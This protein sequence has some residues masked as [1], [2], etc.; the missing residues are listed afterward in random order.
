MGLKSS[1]REI[2]ILNYLGFE[3]QEEFDKKYPPESPMSHLRSFLPKSSLLTASFRKVYLHDQVWLQRQ[4]KRILDESDPRNS[5]ATLGELRA[6]A[7]LL[8]FNCKV[9]PHGT[10]KGTDFSLKDRVGKCVN[11]EVFTMQARPNSTIEWGTTHEVWI[12]KDQTGKCS[13][14]SMTTKISESIP[15]GIPDP[16][17]VGDSTEANMISKICSIKSGGEQA[18]TDTPTLLYIDFQSMDMSYTQL[19]HCC[20]FLSWNGV[21]TAG[22]NWLAFYGE[23]DV[24]IPGKQ[25]VLDDDFVTMQHPGRFSVGNKDNFCGALLS[26]GQ[27]PHCRRGNRMVFFENP[28]RQI[29]PDSFKV[30]I[31]MSSLLNW[32]LSCWQYGDFDQKAYISAQNS[33]LKM[34]FQQFRGK[35]K[36]EL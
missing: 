16:N 19:S 7:D 35:S 34:V 3:T 25:S 22:C 29:L 5:Q 4:K 28:E 10:R 1:M 12:E 18:K 26:Y 11:V 9:I 33:R 2:D 14:C 31:S 23:K 8:D 20:P 21:L 15:Y 32:E 36:L 17:K 24:P 30:S 13:K 6:Y 27:N